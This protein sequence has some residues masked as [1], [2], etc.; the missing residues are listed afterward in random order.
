MYAEWP[1]ALELD[2]TY[3]D[4][5]LFF[6]KVSKVP[7]II[8][9]S[10]INIKGKDAARA[11]ARDGDRTSTITAA[12]LATT[13]VLQEAPPQQAAKAGAKGAAGRA[14]VPARPRRS[15]E[16]DEHAAIPERTV[17]DRGGPGGSRRGD[18]RGR[19]VPHRGR[20]ADGAGT[21]TH[22]HGAGGPGGHDPGAARRLRL[23]SCRPPDP[24]ASLLGRGADLRGPAVRPEGVPGLRIDE[25]TVKGILASRGSYVAIVQAPDN[26]TYTVRAGDKLLDGAVRA[27]S[28]DAIVF[29]QQVSDPLSLVKQREVRK[30]LRSVE[31]GK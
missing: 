1:I 21:A 13:F 20:R 15:G 3:H 19:G 7:R 17:C 5:G 22:P 30:S 31:E 2:G 29:V 14:A 26:K 25:V 12:C 28:A 27:V 9:I 16:D 18:P 6:D 24:F 23:R 8:N 4:L 11:R 10:G